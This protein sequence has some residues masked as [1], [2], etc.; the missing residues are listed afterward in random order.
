MKEVSLGS[1]QAARQVGISYSTAKKIYARFRHQLRGRLQTAPSLPPQALRS[2]VMSIPLGGC[3][4]G[5]PMAIV[6]TIAGR[7]QGKEN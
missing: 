2:E 1:I 6:S 4:W 3:G 7:G 5:A